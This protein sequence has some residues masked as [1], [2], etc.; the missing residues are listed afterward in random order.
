MA[1]IPFLFLDASNAATYM[2]RWKPQMIA[3]QL[4]SVS[5][6]NAYAR[7]HI[8]LR[9]PDC[10]GMLVDIRN[11]G[12]VVHKRAN[13]TYGIVSCLWPKGEPSLQGFRDLREWC[14]C[15]LDVGV[16]GTHLEDELERELWELST[17]DA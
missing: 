10:V 16:D 9:H 2:E 5:G 14:D 4:V 11:M 1:L 13:E 3:D 8:H 7:A 15:M 6:V 17:L 12:Y